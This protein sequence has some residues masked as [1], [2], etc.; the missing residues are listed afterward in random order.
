M[1]RRLLPGVPYMGLLLAI[2]WATASHGILAGLLATLGL[3]ALFLAGVGGMSYAS[4]RSIHARFG[5]VGYYL[6]ATGV[7]MAL[8][9]VMFRGVMGASAWYW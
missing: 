7:L 3:G 6:I 2:L 1:V 5:P 8:L 9:M 4:T